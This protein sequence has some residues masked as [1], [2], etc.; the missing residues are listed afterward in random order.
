M[1]WRDRRRDSAVANKPSDKSG[2]GMLQGQANPNADTPCQGAQ[3]GTLAG[4]LP[5]LTMFVSLSK[6]Q[7]IVELEGDL[8]ILHNRFDVVARG[9]QLAEEQYNVQ[10]TAFKQNDPYDSNM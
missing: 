5:P 4:G 8:R 10:D 9:L 2:R 3:I 6:P 1:F 7:D